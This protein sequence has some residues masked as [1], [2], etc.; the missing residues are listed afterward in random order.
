MRSPVVTGPKQHTADVAEVLN[1]WRAENLSD[2]DRAILEPLQPQMHEHVLA[3]DPVDAQ[4]ARRML[5]PLAHMAVWS[6]KATGSADT[7][8]GLPAAAMSTV[9]AVVAASAARN[10]LESASVAGH[11]PALFPR[12]FRPPEHF[13]APAA[14]ARL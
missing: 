12:R 4:D 3:A 2:I 5:R 10:A 7:D 13:G 9:H 14:W 11:C 8:R 6:V 1:R